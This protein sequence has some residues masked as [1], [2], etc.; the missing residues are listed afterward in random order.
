MN[1]SPIDDDRRTSVTLIPCEFCHVQHSSDNLFHHQVYRFYRRKMFESIKVGI[2][3][4]V[5]PT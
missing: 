3:S 1:R 4:F 5:N 2:F